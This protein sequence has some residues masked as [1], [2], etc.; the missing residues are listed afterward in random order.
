MKNFSL[1]AILFFCS[2]TIA[3]RITVTNAGNG[4]MPN[5]IVDGK[6][7][8]TAYQQKAAEYRALCLQAFNI[9]RERIDEIILQ[10]TTIPKA[11]ITDIDETILDNSAYQ[12]HQVLQGKDYDQSS[13]LEWTAMASADTVPGA[14]DFLKYAAS[15]GVEIFY[16]TNRM[17]KERDATIKNLKKFDLPNADYAH[18][19]PVQK[20]SSKEDRRKSIA[21]NHDV[22][23]LLG[24]N[25]A[26]FSFL[27]DKKNSL[28]RTENVNVLSGEFGRRFIILPNPVYGDW[29]SSL[30]NYN[31]SLLAAQ[32][33]SLLKA[34]L[35]TY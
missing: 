9:A 31:Y 33:D 2:C 1:F 16:V 4:G 7:F 14:S 30:Y 23:M 20:T 8:A 35:H 11:I 6:I 10:N 17:E 12:A 26:D 13:W 15:K 27:F 19:F 32:K 3:P 24:D 29:E 5:V 34:S 28:Q 25:L 18:L 22:V 21:A